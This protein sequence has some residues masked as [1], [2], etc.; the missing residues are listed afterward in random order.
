MLVLKQKIIIFREKAKI[1]CKKII[2]FINKM[3]SYNFHLPFF[4]HL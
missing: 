1:Q 2:K 3:K 4:V